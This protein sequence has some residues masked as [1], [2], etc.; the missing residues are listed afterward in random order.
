MPQRRRA[1]LPLP[2]ALP[3]TATSHTEQTMLDGIRVA[4]QS[5]FGRIFMAIIMLVIVTSFAIFGIGDIFRGFGAGKVAEVGSTEISAEALR[6]AYQSD[7]QAV[8]AP[9]A[10]RRHQRRGAV[11]WRGQPGRLHA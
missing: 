3:I 4:S 6:F 10:A 8:A 1:T 5:I 7:L 9:V 11:A 2:A